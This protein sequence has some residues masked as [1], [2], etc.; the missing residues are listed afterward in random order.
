MSY[1]EGQGARVPSAE[2]DGPSAVRFNHQNESSFRREYPS[3][4]AKDPG[5]VN[6]IRVSGLGSGE[7]SRVTERF[8]AMY[9]AEFANVFRAV[10]LVC[11]DRGIA[12]DATQEAFARALARWRRLR[13]AP[14]AAGWVTTTAINVARR[15]LRRSALPPDAPAGE[16]DR[17]AVLDL[18]AA[19]RH[20]PSRQQE[21]VALHYLL[22]L[23]I[24][25][26]ASAMGCDEG[27]VKTHLSRARA[28]LGRLLGR[29]TETDHIEARTPNDG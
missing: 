11:G 22:D 19:V 8:Q 26:A 7:G 23:P 9:E 20:L 15:E 14:W 2:G 4:V 27:T 25:H 12:E 5:R 16:S 29:E 6:L 1:A 18:R 17:E 21:A 13:D 28:T 10:A 3:P 24:A